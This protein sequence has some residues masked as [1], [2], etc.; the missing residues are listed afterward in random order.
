MKSLHIITLFFILY[1]NCVNSYRV[2][3]LCP[4]LKSPNIE[5]VTNNAISLK[6]DNLQDPVIFNKVSKGKFK[7]M[8]QSLKPFD[9]IHYYLD[10]SPVDAKY[11]NGKNTKDKIIDSEINKIATPEELGNT[12]CQSGEYKKDEEHKRNRRSLDLSKFDLPPL[13]LPQL[14]KVG[15]VTNN[16]K[17]KTDQIKTLENQVNK[18]IGEVDERLDVITKSLA[19]TKNETQELA[20]NVV[21]DKIHDVNVDVSNKFDRL[22]GEIQEWRDKYTLQ[23][24]SMHK[25][26]ADYINKVEDKM[27][28][29]NESLYKNINDEQSFK[30]YINE[31][32]KQDIMKHVEMVNKT[33]E[34]IKLNV[35]RKLDENNSRF[36]HFSVLSRLIHE[37]K[38]LMDIMSNKSSFETLLMEN[39]NHESTDLKI[40]VRRR[41]RGIGAEVLF[42]TADSVK[43]IEDGADKLIKNVIVKPLSGL[44]P[45]EDLKF[46]NENSQIPNLNI[47]IVN[48][49]TIGILPIDKNS[50]SSTRKPEINNSTT[51]ASRVRRSIDEHAI[52]DPV[53]S[54]INQNE[55][56]VNEPVKSISK[57]V[58]GLVTEIVEPISNVAESI[59]ADILKPIQKSSSN[60]I[61]P[62][63]DLVNVGSKSLNKIVSNI[64]KPISEFQKPLENVGNGITN[65]NSNFNVIGLD[66]KTNQREIPES[67][68]IRPDGNVI[69]DV[70]S[71]IKPV[72]SIFSK[73]NS[74]FDS[75]KME[76]KKSK[77]SAFYSDSSKQSKLSSKDSKRQSF[78]TLRE[79]L[80]K[81]ATYTK[82]VYNRITRILQN[83]NEKTK[84]SANLVHM[85]GQDKD[86]DFKCYSFKLF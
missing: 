9:Y 47:N 38:I 75:S 39:Q 26:L 20:K 82:I 60:L 64:E 27:K 28:N 61:N 17:S 13:P 24:D 78:S 35:D 22:I 2:R 23:A 81:T 54:I 44:F 31:E 34:D 71:S 1:Q 55:N 37:I 8:Y 10:D 12:Y 53:T 46:K 21:N 68:L 56:V 40:D 63:G 7:E 85:C 77:R 69:D 25:N 72:S 41:K 70:A 5:G 3:D 15:P 19:K 45:I 52:V 32:V 73:F 18:E 79:Q 57:Q 6:S 66:K 76:F 4:E 67:S 58:G 16:K 59:V 62:I 42:K 33:A 84:S 86:E 50:T 83:K 11:I 43:H 14:S 74:N 51:I 36:E 29:M 65:P 49:E 30:K 48:G 80:R